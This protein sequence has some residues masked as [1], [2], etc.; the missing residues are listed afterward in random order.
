MPQRKHTREEEE[1][2]INDPSNVDESGESK[3]SRLNEEQE[4]D[5]RR[6]PSSSPRRYS[7][8][9]LL[10]WGVLDHV[11]VISP[12]KLEFSSER[13]VDETLCLKDYATSSR[14]S[15]SLRKYPC[16][17]GGAVSCF[18]LSK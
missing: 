5:E 2:V 6:R 18:R 7:I 11:H 13:W 16:I 8:R 4:G 17:P 1:V 10:G 15:G 9:E 3:R 12:M 14:K